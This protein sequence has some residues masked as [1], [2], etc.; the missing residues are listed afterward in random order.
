MQN[1]GSGTSRNTVILAYLGCAL[2]WGTT[3]FAI[4]VC[5]EPSA[6]PAYIAA[7]L[8]FSLASLCLALG[9][10][11][12]RKRIINPTR[13]ELIWIPFSG[14]LSG[15]AYGM[16]YAAEEHIAGGLAAVISAT[17]PMIAA[18]IAM[19]TRTE[20]PTRATISGAIVA[21]FGVALVFH[22]RMQIS[23]AE[24]SAVGILLIVACLNSSST[25]AMKRHARNTAPL[26]S[27]TI[28]FSSA[29]LMLWIVAGINGQWKIPN[30]I[31][32][33][34][35]LAL[36]YLTI[37]G[38]LIAFGAFFYLLKHTRLSTVMT[39]SFV[40]PIIA[41]VIDAFFEKHCVLTPE[42]Y[43][44]IAVVLAGVAVSILFKRE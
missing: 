35:T 2:I 3:W 14:L 16:L 40:T 10:F 19:F 4:R 13:T 37:F 20:H 12:Y 31:P 5:I 8:R 26:A 36:L 42:S 21:F 7:A 38:T 18:M 11:V 9:W 41:L 25:V 17:S 34:P 23:A 43:L 15:L 1:A 27:N 22:G 28:F 24:A 6:Y 44:G 29:S 33:G 30:P 32:F 39:L